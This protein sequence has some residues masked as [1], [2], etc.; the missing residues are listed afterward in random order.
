M[1]IHKSLRSGSGLTRA[2]N[3]LTRAER[4]ERM[5]REGRLKPGDPV[6]GLPKT[7]VFKAKKV[8]KKKKV[9]EDGAEAT[10]TEETPAE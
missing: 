5:T 4:V 2:R 8:K 3:V 10:T 9:E 1:S 7:K 6:I